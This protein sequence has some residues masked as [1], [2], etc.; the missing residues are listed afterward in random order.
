[1]ETLLPLDVSHWA[2]GAKF[3]GGCKRCG[4]SVYNLD[5]L[6]EDA[7]EARKTWRAV[8]RYVRKSSGL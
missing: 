4:E 5:D 2:K 8:Q 6:A 7:T 1:M 3:T